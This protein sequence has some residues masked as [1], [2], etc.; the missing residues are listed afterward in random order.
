MDVSDLYKYAENGMRK[1]TGPPCDWLKLLNTSEWGFRY[2]DKTLN[3]WNSFEKNDV[4][5]FHS[6]KQEYLPQDPSIKTGIIGIGISDRKCCIKDE[7]FDGAFTPAGL[8]P[9]KLHFSNVWFFGNVDKIVN[10]SIS[11]R[12]SKGYSYILRDIYNLTY[13]AI[14]FSEMR[15]HNCSIPTQGAVA[16]LRDDRSKNLMQLIK[17][18]RSLNPVN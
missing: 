1:I 11:T 12:K 16:R 4:F 6:M 14:S 3:A 8:R 13:N 18:T 9:L 17:N 5:V 2:Y 15:E 10:E 7:P